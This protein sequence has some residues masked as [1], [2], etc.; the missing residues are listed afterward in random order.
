M[1]QFFALNLAFC[2]LLFSGIVLAHPHHLEQMEV[3]EQVI[4]EEVVPVVT[5]K[6]IPHTH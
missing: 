4:D 6:E 5:I 1:K 3:E 2:S